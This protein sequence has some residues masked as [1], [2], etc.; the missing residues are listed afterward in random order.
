MKSWFLNS[1]STIFCDACLISLWVVVPFKSPCLLNYEV[2]SKNN[3]VVVCRYFARI[4]SIRDNVCTEHYFMNTCT[5]VQRAFRLC[6]KWTLWSEDNVEK[7]TRQWYSPGLSSRR[8]RGKRGRLFFR[9]FLEKV[10]SNQLPN[11]FVYYYWITA[12]L[13]FIHYFITK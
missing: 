11:M 3:V 4:R 10:E 6:C 13:V 1:V 8:K 5:Y 12:Q 7:L 2:G 9:G